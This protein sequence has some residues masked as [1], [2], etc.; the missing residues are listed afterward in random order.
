MSLVTM[1]FP[2]VWERIGMA[3]MMPMGL[4]EVSLGFWLLIKGLRNPSFST[5]P[6]K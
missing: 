5:P 4:F 1:I 3:Y 2:A 6:A